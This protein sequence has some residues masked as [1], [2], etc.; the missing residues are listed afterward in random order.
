MKALTVK[1]AN[2]KIVA[3]HRAAYM[4]GDVSHKDYYLWLADFIGLEHIEISDKKIKASK[5]PH[6][7]DIPLFLWD[8]MDKRVR[9]MAFSKGL[10]CWSLSD[11]VCVAKA[12]AEKIRG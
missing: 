5:D 1:Q 12:I 10:I 6:F 7:N 9:A 4:A 2:S 8:R 11:T 3:E